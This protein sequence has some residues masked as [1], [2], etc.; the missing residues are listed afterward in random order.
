MRADVNPRSA[1]KELVDNAIDNWRRLENE[2][3][4]LLVEIEHLSADESETGQEELVIR[5]N[6]GGLEEENLKMFFALGESAKESTES[7][8][9]AFGIGCKRIN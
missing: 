2:N 3:G 8:I 6:S 1:I 9:G 7:S 5:D 4:E